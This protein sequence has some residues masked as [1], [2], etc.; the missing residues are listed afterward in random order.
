MLHVTYNVESG[1]Q[2][3]F[4]TQHITSIISYALLLLFLFNLLERGVMRVLVVIARF[5]LL[6][7]VAICYL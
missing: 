1:G 4:H 6:P 3:N 2:F 7:I 5:I